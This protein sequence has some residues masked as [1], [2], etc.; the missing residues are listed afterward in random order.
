MP[1][2]GLGIGRPQQLFGGIEIEMLLWH[3][4]QDVAYPLPEEAVKQLQASVERLQ[5]Q[6]EVER[7]RAD[8]LAEYVDRSAL[9]QTTRLTKANAR[10]SPQLQHNSC[11]RLERKPPDVIA[12][13]GR[14]F[15]KLTRSP[16]LG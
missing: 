5:R 12:S 13:G 15:A 7:Q 2:V 8:R 9:T 1:E 10:D 14:Y 11:A 16:P 3:D 6:P 4:K